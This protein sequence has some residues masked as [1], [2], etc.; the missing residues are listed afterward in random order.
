MSEPSVDVLA[1]LQ[2]LSG[3]V[4]AV[5]QSDVE[6]SERTLEPLARS[7]LELSLQRAR[8][9]LARLDGSQP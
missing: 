8:E 3:A 7:A 5:C 4:D 2:D 6:A 9:V 1:A